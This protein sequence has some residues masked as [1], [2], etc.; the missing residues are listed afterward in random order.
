MTRYPLTWKERSIPFSLNLFLSEFTQ[1][2][3]Q[4]SLKVEVD[5][6]RCEVVLVKKG[7]GVELLGLG[8]KDNS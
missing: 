3:A 5:H 1:Y 8:R 4:G 2:K 6:S 7:Q